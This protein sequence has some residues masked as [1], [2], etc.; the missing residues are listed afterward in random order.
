MSCMK[1]FLNF[2][3]EHHS[4]LRRVTGTETVPSRETTMWGGGTN[5]TY[6]RCHAEHVCRECGETREE[7]NCLC[8]RAVAD[9][10]PVRLAWIAQSNS[11][12]SAGA[13]S[14]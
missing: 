12:A 6:V 14:I 13:T 9:H 7:G 3:W 10:C 2:R 8:D 1:H 5:T 4:W 11:G